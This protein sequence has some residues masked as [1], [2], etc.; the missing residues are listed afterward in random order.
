MKI[1]KNIWSDPVWSKVI[2]TGILALLAYYI[3]PDKWTT[4]IISKVSSLVTWFFGLTETPNWLLTIMAICVFLVV[5]ILVVRLLG[6]SK[7]RYTSDIFQ[8]V[9]W[10]WTYDSLGRVSDLYPCCVKCQCQTIPNDV[11]AYRTQPKIVFICPSCDDVTSIFDKNTF[12]IEHEVKL[13]IQQKI[14]T[15]EY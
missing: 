8:G 5:I 14:R 7:Q 13:F 9:E 2:A 10:H 3:S 11:G 1:F 12:D 4:Y 6:D 15:K